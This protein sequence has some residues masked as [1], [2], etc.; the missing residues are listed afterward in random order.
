MVNRTCGAVLFF[1]G[2]AA[3]GQA[4]AQDATLAIV[5]GRLI[6]GYGGPPIHDSV[7]LVSGNRITAV[8]TQTDIVVPDKP[9]PATTSRCSAS[10]RA[11]AG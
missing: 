5:G 10:K 11:S 4:I 8:G 1:C 3:G 6:D 9:S 2:L 7:V